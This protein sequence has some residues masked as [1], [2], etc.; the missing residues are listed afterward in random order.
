MTKRAIF[1]RAGQIIVLGDLRN[2]VNPLESPVNFLAVSGGT[3]AFLKAFGEVERE[4]V[5][6]SQNV[7]RLPDELFE[8]KY[9]FAISVGKD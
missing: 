8:V 7:F 4:L 9:T 3:R 2:T 1:V 6:P 5:P